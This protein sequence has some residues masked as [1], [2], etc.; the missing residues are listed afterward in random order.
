MG[1]VVH[2]HGGAPSVVILIIDD[3][4]IVALESKRDPPIGLHGHRPMPQ[5]LPLSACSRRRAA[6]AAAAW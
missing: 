3:M 2:A 4:R 1:R 6:T 5:S